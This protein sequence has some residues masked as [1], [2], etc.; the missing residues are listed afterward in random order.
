[1]LLNTATIIVNDVR[2]YSPIRADARDS[3]VVRLALN[4]CISCLIHA[5][6][7]TT[8]E[9]DIGMRDGWII[10]SRDCFRGIV[11]VMAR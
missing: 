7:L 5:R 4:A 2:T 3:S 1:M 9:E 11:W 10:R 8:L 6:I